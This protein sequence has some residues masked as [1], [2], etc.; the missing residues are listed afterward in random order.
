[1]IVLIQI[2]T[3][4]LAIMIYKNIEP[5]N[6]YFLKRKNQFELNTNELKKIAPFPK[7]S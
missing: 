5:E 1:M 7:N 6:L 4:L 2:I 3:S